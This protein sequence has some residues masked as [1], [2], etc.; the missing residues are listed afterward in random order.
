MLGKSNKAKQSPIGKLP[1][2]P[3]AHTHSQ[4]PGPSIHNDPKD[5]IHKHLVYTTLTYNSFTLYTHENPVLLEHLLDGS[6]GSGSSSAG[7]SAS[8]NARR[9]SCVEI[10]N[11]QL[12]LINSPDAFTI[13]IIPVASITNLSSSTRTAVQNNSLTL[14]YI[15]YRYNNSDDL[16][17]IVTICSSRLKKEIPLSILDKILASYKGFRSKKDEQLRLADG[18]SGQNYGSIS[19]AGKRPVNN[20]TNNTTNNIFNDVEFKPEFANIIIQEEKKISSLPS[21]AVLTSMPSSASAASPD[22]NYYLTSEDYANNNSDLA[23]LNIEFVTSELNDLKKIMND[24]VD[25]IMERNERIGLLVNKT[26]KINSNSNAFKRRTL[27][28]KR[29]LWWNTIKFKAILAFI[30]TFVGYL[31]IGEL[32]C[33]LPFYGRCFYHG[34]SENGGDKTGSTALEFRTNILD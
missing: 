31:V 1:L 23:N 12:S 11:S 18:G 10:I 26:D 3:L 20:N 21:R 34:G 22:N 17:T 9:I 25:R 28:L 6:G 15:K 14:Y 19:G 32:G 7:G 13:G 16:I 24:N 2:L 4:G 27:L 33:G 29:K 5:E 30:V 8:G